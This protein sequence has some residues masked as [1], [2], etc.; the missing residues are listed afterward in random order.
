MEEFS[1]SAETWTAL[2]NYGSI[3]S[4]VGFF[5]TLYLFW[6]IRKIKNDFLSRARIPKLRLNFNRHT[7]TVSDLLRDYPKTHEEVV[8]IIS[9]ARSDIN[10]LKNKSP[11]K[12]IKQSLNTL[13]LDIEFFI[14]HE[15]SIELKPKLRSIYLQMLKTNQDIVNHI[16]D[17]KLRHG[18]G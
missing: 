11:T 3:A 1:L 2:G 16:E 12:D 5:I 8:K 15:P 7:S 13:G 17:D 9:I 4:I 14:K 18:N 6:A 10:S